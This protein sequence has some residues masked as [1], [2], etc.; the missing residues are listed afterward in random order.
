V[1]DQARNNYLTQQVPNPFA[2]LM[3]ASAPAGFRGATIARQ[4]LLRPYPHFGNITTTANDGQSWYNALQLNLERRFSRGY[5]FSANYTYSRFEE[6]LVRLNA[7]DPAP[8]RMISDM[9]TPH[10]VSL[11]GIWELPFG[12]GRMFG[13]DMSPLATTSSAAGRSRASIST[14]PARR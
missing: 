2:G 8:T 10:K 7:G 12:H 13:R 14:R 3:P 11:S 9:D 6:A 1:R 5:T 4:Q